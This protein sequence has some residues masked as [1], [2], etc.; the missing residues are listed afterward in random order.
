MDA[1]S[2]SKKLR[3]AVNL[4]TATLINV[5]IN[6]E[7]VVGSKYEMADLINCQNQPRNLELEAF[8]NANKLCDLESVTI[9]LL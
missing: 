7:Y 5:F 3:I 8:I 9:V 4:R 6:R 1:E 2:Q